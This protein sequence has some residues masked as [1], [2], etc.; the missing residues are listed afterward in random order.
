MHPTFD[1]LCHACACSSLSCAGT[2]VSVEEVQD[3]TLENPLDNEEALQEQLETLPF[4]CRFQYERMAIYLCS[5]MD[6]LLAQYRAV[7]TQQA[8]V[9]SVDLQVRAP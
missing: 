8:V 3:A 2:T 9:S 7:S 5:V 6:P 4:L 1:S